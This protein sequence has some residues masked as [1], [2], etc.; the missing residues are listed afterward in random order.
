MGQTAIEE[1]ERLTV[2]PKAQ[3]T[4]PGATFQEPSRMP[5]HPHITKGSRRCGSEVFWSPTARKNKCYVG[6]VSPPIAKKTMGLQI[7]F[8]PVPK[9]TSYTKMK[10]TKTKK[11]R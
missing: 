2:S 10:M 11:R 3:A 5:P 7:G 9:K 6:E 8:T 1:R 4:E